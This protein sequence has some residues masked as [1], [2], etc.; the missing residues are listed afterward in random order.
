ME[1]KGTFGFEA[2]GQGQIIHTQPHPLVTASSIL[3]ASVTE[4]HTG[5]PFLGAANNISIANLV[6][7]NGSILVVINTNWSG[8]NI[9]VKVS[10]IIAL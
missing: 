8:S 2:A 4:V 5:I 6:P 7:Q 3:V 1:I 9:S 10:G